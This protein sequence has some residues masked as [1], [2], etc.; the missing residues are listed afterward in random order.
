MYSTEVPVQ[1][2]LFRMV[3][4]SLKTVLMNFVP[5][6]AI[7]AALAQGQTSSPTVQTRALNDELLRVHGEIQRAPRA[8][9]ARG[10]AAGII[11]KRAAALRALIKTDPAQAIQMAFSPELLADLSA[12]FPVSAARFETHGTWQGP[13]EYRIY[14]GADG[15]HWSQILMTVGSEEVE[16]HFAGTEPANLSSGDVVEATG[17]LLGSD[18]AV[19]SGITQPL[20]A[21]KAA[22][23]GGA[24]LSCSATGTQ[25]TAVLLLNLPNAPLPANITQPAMQDMFFSSTTRS[26]D[27]YFRETSY[28]MTSAAGNTFGPYTLAGSYSGCNTSQMQLD[29][30]AAASAAGVN[31]KAYTRLFMVFPDNIG[32]GWAGMGTMGCSTVSAPSGSFTAS[33]SYVA[34]GYAN[35]QVATHEAGHNLRL[36]HAQTRD[37]GT[38]ALGPL[39]TP[40]IL[41]E[42]G[43]EFSTMGN[44]I[45]GHYAASQRPDIGM[46]G[47]RHGLS[48]RA[49]Q[50]NV[51]HSAARNELRHAG[52]QSPARHREQC[53]AVDRVPP[54]GGQLRHKLQH[55]PALFRRSD[56][57]RGF[58]DG[59]VFTTAR[60]HTRERFERLRRPGAGSGEI[61]GRSVHE[62]IA[63]GEQCYFECIECDCQLRRR[64]LHAREPGCE[65]FAGES[66]RRRG[67]QRQLHG[68][69]GQ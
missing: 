55:D 41:S 44:W 38:E 63:D 58:D 43:D 49:D 67:R 59:R 21:V 34:A 53:L 9:F 25:S 61:V 4:R 35:V 46:D 11:E 60:F 5:S 8:T 30:I 51:H 68:H 27:G 28:G 36:Q 18:M 23:K 17:I 56:S 24:G 10:Q 50:R 3:M 39:A 42:Y 1:F 52:S 65:H 31:L 29:A 37:F 15:S 19:A 13:V 12:K 40:G 14:D 2:C 57:L 54:T 48:D 16:L 32:C 7:C 26:M 33:S 69:V 20:S 47:R 64:A 62:S 22:G 45:P 66:E 6:L